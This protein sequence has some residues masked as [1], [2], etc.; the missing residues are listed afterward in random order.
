MRMWSQGRQ[1][2]FNRRGE[3]VSWLFQR[4]EDKID[5]CRK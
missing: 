2:E 4:M 1:E 3:G 5:K